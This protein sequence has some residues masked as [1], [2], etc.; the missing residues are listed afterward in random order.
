MLVGTP[1]ILTL[2]ESDHLLLILVNDVLHIIGVSVDHMMQVLVHL[3]LRFHLGRFVFIGTRMNSLLVEPQWRNPLTTVGLLALCF[4]GV[5]GNQR[6]S[7]M[8]SFR[9]FP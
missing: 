3:V 5:D 2:S 9:P 7:L 8:A 1:S 6:H 4:V